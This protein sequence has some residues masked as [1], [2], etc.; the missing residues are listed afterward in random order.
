M[1]VEKNNSEK[2]AQEETLIQFP[3][4]FPIKAMG[5]GMIDL[6]K[7]VLSIVQKHAIDVTE[8]DIALKPSRNGRYISVTVTINA[9]SKMQLDA[10][11]QAMTD[12]K[13]ILMV[14]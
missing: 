4:R 6:D 3:C 14:F 2:S 10:I 8:A 11:Y 7:T 5:V 1:T 12:H 13:D 9:H